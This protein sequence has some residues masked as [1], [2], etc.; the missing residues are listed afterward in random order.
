[1][2]TVDITG[3]IVTATGTPVPGVVVELA[4]NSLAPGAAVAIDGVA[5]LQA[6]DSVV[7]NA[8]GDFTITAQQGFSYTLSIG[9]IGYSR[10]FVAPAAV[11][12]RFDLL[13]LTPVLETVADYTDADGTG[14]VRLTVKAADVA[15]V[16]QRFDKIVLERAETPAGPW[17]VETEIDLEAGVNF[18]NYVATFTTTTPTDAWR[19]KYAT[20]DDSDNSSYSDVIDGNAGESDLVVSVEELKELYLF[21]VDLTDGDGTPYPNRLLRHYIEVGIAW[22]EKELDIPIVA[23][24]I[25]DEKHDH[26]AVDYG[27]WGYI[28]LDKYPVGRI[29]KVA[30]QYPSQDEEVEIDPTWVVLEDDGESGVIQIVPGQGNIAD[31]L[32]IPGSLMPMWD[33]ATGRVPGVWKIS[34]RAGFEVGELPADLKHVIS[35]AASIGVLNIAGDL[36]AGAGIASISISV[37]GLSQS[38]G[39]TSSATNSGYGARIGEYQKEIKEA[40]PNLRRYYGKNTRMVVA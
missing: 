21:G 34:Y 17:V 31:V 32:L 25:V 19:V 33:G 18:Y 15:V 35:M 14:F 37:P 40:L 2:P 24:S 1:M 4:P 16:L 10:S 23:R 13:G 27:R 5:V 39:T 29:D 7:T 26:Y 8:S 11:S 36:I 6:P 22:L 20:T 38:I 28:Q 30:F 12:V 9:A 3:R